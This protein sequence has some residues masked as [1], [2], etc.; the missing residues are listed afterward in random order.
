MTDTTRTAVAEALAM[1][2]FEDAI[3]AYRKQ[4]TR[5]KYRA[6]PAVRDNWLRKADRIMADLD[7]NPAAKAALLDWL[8]ADQ[9]GPGGSRAYVDYDPADA[10][11]SS[12]SVTPASE[13]EPGLRERLAKAAEDAAFEQE[14]A[15]NPTE[16]AFHEG[17]VSAYHAASEW[18]AAVPAVTPTSTET[19]RA[20]LRNLAILRHDEGGKMSAHIV[21]NEIGGT[22]WPFERCP[23]RGCELAR[24]ALSSPVS[25]E[26]RTVTTGTPTW[27]D[28]VVR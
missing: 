11:P 12:E 27:R 21:W 2:L 3:A 5:D 17:R 6:D 23:E 13:V 26:E 28:E 9:R 20:A 14:M 19:L 22:R 16:K 4:A 24:A 25:S 18:V 15:H 10:A 7:A 8:L 1:L